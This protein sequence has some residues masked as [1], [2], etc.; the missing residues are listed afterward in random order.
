MQ[1][2][3]RHL[4]QER[5]MQGELD[6]VVATSAFGMGVD[7]SSIRFVLHYDHP[8]SLEA[9]IQEAGRAGRDGLTAYAILLY[10]Q[11]SQKTER[12]IARQGVP[13]M[14]VLRRYR[15]ALLSLNEDDNQDDETRTVIR[16]ADSSIVFD[17]D[18]LADLTRVETTQAR[19]LLYSFEEAGLVQRNADCTIE[20]ALSLDRPIEQAIS[21]L[22]NEQERV[23]AEALLKALRAEP[24]RIVTYRAS[25][26]YP[27]AGID[28]RIIDSL[29]VKLTERQVLLYRA[30]S[31]GINL[32]LSSLLQNSQQLMTISQGFAT[33]YQRFEERL[34]AMLDY[35][36]LKRGQNNCRSADL[37]NYLTGRD[38]TPF[39]G[40]CDLCSPEDTNLPWKPDHRL[41]GEKLTVDVRLSILGAVR[42]HNAIFGRVTIEQMLRGREKF[43]HGPQSKPLATAA[44]SSDHF[45]E[46]ADRSISNDQ[47]HHTFD[48]LI[49]GGFL[50][51][52]EKQ[53]R[54]DTTRPS[55]QAIAITQKGR[56]A[57]AGGVPLPTQ[58]MQEKQI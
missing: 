25:E 30:Y 40:K 10:H 16:L 5:F 44:R 42:D 18:A 22:D 43:G 55:Y 36:R 56:D 46:L 2:A 7:K 33:R 14:Q 20:A 6:V 3:E 37:I 39:C 23:V 57:L 15:N 27:T 28:P 8:A 49:E 45:A 17:P 53:W 21:V 48:A 19:I 52:I 47:V 13:D 38:D 12:F 50:Q 54:N 32:R 24:N 29:L 11:Q 34:Q 35:I 58:E 9:Y 41:Y 51:S 31:R 4:V 26:V 1:T